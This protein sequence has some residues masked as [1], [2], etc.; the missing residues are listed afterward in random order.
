MS[1]IMELL[2][3][4]PSTR[5]QVVI[6]RF[7]ALCQ[8]GPWFESLS[9]DYHCGWFFPWFPWVCAHNLQYSEYCYETGHHIFLTHFY[10]LTAQYCYAE[11]CESRVSR[12]TRQWAGNPRNGSL[13]LTIC[14][15]FIS[16]SD[17]PAR[18][19]D[20]SLRSSAS[21]KNEWSS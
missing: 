18:E 4:G 8:G 15:T 7:P 17:W 20:H 10:K 16:S 11:S 19:A 12:A 13:I 9:E 21:I 1:V 2:S 5:H 14:R 3:I 6:V